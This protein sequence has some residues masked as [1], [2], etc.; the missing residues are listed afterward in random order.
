MNRRHVL[1][2]AAAFSVLPVSGFAEVVDVITGA[3]ATVPAPI[4]RIWSERLSGRGIASLD[5]RPIGSS[6]GAEAIGSRRVDFGTSDLPL[7]PATLHKFDLVQFPIVLAALGI[8]VNLPKLEQGQ[9]HLD[10]DLLRDI[11]AGRIRIWTHPR[12]RRLNPGLDLPH[13]QITPVV[14]ADRSGSSAMI[15]DYMGG[16]HPDLTQDARNAV[17]TAFG[18]AAVG[19]H[20]IAGT[21]ARIEGAIGYVELSVAMQYG[22]TR[23]A[24]R[25]PDGRF[26]A[27][28][29]LSLASSARA[30]AKTADEGQDMA[31]LPAP[32]PIVTQSHAL[33]ATDQTQQAV[34]RAVT[35]FFEAAFR[36]GDELAWTAGFAPLD[37]AAKRQARQIWRNLLGEG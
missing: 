35:G 4:L 5:Y 15:A 37:T 10:P 14:R 26:A 1:A 22:L 34:N 11:F 23:V 33:L 3:G 18:L 36:S 13:L 24:L 2:G 21:V 9:L 7:D 20:G 30:Q 27:P 25:A 31:G 17:A 29:R 6:A 28:D 8:V 12:V 19:G 16:G 32:W